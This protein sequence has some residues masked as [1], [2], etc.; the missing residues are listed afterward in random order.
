MNN[1]NVR[2]AP[3]PTGYL[4]VGGLRTA[5]YNYLFAKQNNGNL[6]LRIEDTDQSR[7][8]DGA[9]SNLVESL[10]K[11][12]IIFDKGP[13]EYDKND[14]FIQ[15]NRLHLYH[16]A[17]ELLLNDGYAYIC[18]DDNFQ[19]YRDKIFS[20]EELVNKE[21]HVRL[22]IP[23]NELSF[24][25]D[26]R[27]KIN[28]DL[29]LINDPVILKTDGFPT[30][31]L[32][33]VVDDH[34]MQIS[35]VIRGEEWLPSTPIHVLLYQYF[36]W[37]LPVFIHLPLLLN[38]DKSKLSKRQ[39]HVA[40]D[41]FLNEGYLADALINFIA[42]LGWNP[43][44]N[45]ELF[46]IDQLIN[47]F[48]INN[49]QKAG[50]VF[51]IDKLNWMNAQYLK[52][53]EVSQLLPIA[54]KIFINNNFIIKDESDLVSIIEF[55]KSRCNTIK[56]IVQLANPFFQDLAY[57]PDYLSL[58][59]DSKSKAIYLIL[60]E[61]LEGLQL[62]SESDIKLIISDIGNKMNLKGKDLFFPI[63]L[64]IWGDVHGPDIGLI[65]KILEKEK[66]LE[67]LHRALN[68]GK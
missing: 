5:L 25:D 53:T 42:L 56:D 65:I 50:A 3:S 37:E 7:K 22:K 64:A 47:Q 43:K 26:I 38:P 51:D 36:N 6:I 4:H 48:N 20:K 46:S 12:G 63:R 32:A 27:G 18:L 39:G 49:V 59:A 34:D 30:Y 1:I 29:S 15:S 54:K 57:H 66:S 67:R 58:L 19:K 14:L 40:V 31:H 8:V 60:I 33:N 45:D 2:F 44:T 24:D 68:Y 61:K 23:N 21:Y 55:G 28:F 35:H 10:N 52:T 13:E 11:C 9:I 41:D 17:V 62:V 16:D